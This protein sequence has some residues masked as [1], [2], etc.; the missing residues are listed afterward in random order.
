MYM[1][2]ICLSGAGW[3]AECLRVLKS[4]VKKRHGAEVWRL[5]TMVG[6]FLLIFWCS[7]VLQGFKKTN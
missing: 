7:E 6:S 4:T 3:L 5:D 2:I 1:Y